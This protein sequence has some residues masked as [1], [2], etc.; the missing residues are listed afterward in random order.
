MNYRVF[1]TPDALQNLDDAVYYYKNTASA[2]VASRFLGDYKNT[3]AKIVETKYF[4]VFFENFR[5]LPMK[6]FPYIVFYTLDESQ[7]IIMIKAVFHTSQN[8]EKYP[9]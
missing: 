6:K 1:V 8:P 2:K 7:K 5:G 3:L 9:E 4:Q